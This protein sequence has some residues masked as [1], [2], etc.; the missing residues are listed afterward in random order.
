MINSSAARVGQRQGGTHPLRQE[1]ILGRPR[2]GDEGH[3]A[4]VLSSIGSR[5]QLQNAA[6]LNVLISSDPN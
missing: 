1:I 6:I 2:E 5:G 4:L 3:L